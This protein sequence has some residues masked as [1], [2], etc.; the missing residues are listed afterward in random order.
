MMIRS[1]ANGESQGKPQT[2]TERA[3]KIDEAKIRGH[4]DRVVGRV[5]GTQLGICHYAGVH[6]VSRPRISNFS[7]GEPYN[8]RT[9]TGAWP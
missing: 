6:S 9:Q 7:G 8:M 1:P 4:F 2:G 5:F 3:F